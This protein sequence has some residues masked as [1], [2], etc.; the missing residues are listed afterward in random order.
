MITIAGEP[1]YLYSLRSNLY[2]LK[3]HINEKHKCK[4][5]LV[6]REIRLLNWVNERDG[7]GYIPMRYPI[8]FIIAITI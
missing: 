8:Y 4:T 2:R 7:I 1:K 5:V 6:A 3:L